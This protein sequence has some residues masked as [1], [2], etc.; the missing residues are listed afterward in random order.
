MLVTSAARL[1]FGGLLLDERQRTLFYNSGLSA[2]G[3]AVLRRSL[4]CRSG[5][6]WRACRCRRQALVRIALATPVLLPPYV[7]ALAWAY[8]GGSAGVAAAVVGR[9]L[10]SGWTYSLPAAA[11]VLALVYYPIVMLATEAAL[12][13]MEPRLEEA[14]IWPLR[15]AACW[16]G[17]RCRWWRPQSAGPA[18]IVFVLAISE[19]GV[20]ALLRVRVYTTEV[21]TAFAALFDFARATALTLPL[22]VLAAGT[23]AVAAALLGGRVMAG[24]RTGAC[25]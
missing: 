3:T 20:P 17:S 10:F 1:P 13:Q 22:L 18:L 23:S 5:S 12:R 11:V 2:G 4:A 19:F 21:F 8:I 25:Y 7:V 24:Q 16:P 9:D 6:A 15:H 14:G